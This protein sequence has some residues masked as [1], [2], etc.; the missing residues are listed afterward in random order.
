[1]AV[2]LVLLGFAGGFGRL[3]TLGQAFAGPAVPTTPR[4]GT[5]SRTAHATPPLVP[6][7]AATGTPPGATI[8]ASAGTT[9]SHAGPGATGHPVV[10]PGGGGGG[11]GGNGGPSGGNGGSGS[12]GHH[13]GGT[14]SPTPTPTPAPPPTAKPTPIDN[15]VNLGTSI[16]NKVPGPVGTVATQLLQNLG[17]NIDGLLPFARSSPTTAQQASGSATEQ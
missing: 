7:P 9:A 11:T 3:G 10:V 13:G 8:I 12:G 14:P 1:M 4:A 16:T 2:A 17:R 15:V 5:P 6:V